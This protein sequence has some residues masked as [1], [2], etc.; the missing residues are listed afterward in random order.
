MSSTGRDRRVVE[1]AWRAFVDGRI[2]NEV[3]PEVV[4]SWR[5]SST[6]PLGID[7]AP[8]ADDAPSRWLASPV[9]R[10]FQSIESELTGVALEGDFVAAVTDADGTIVWT[11]AGRAMRRRAERVHFAPGGRW[12][13]EAV[14]TNALGL[15]LRSDEACTVWSAEHY[16]PIVHDWVCYSAPIHDPVTRRTCGVIDLS[17]TWHQAHPLAL[18]TVKSLARLLDHALTGMGSNGAEHSSAPIDLRTLGRSELLLD[19]RVRSLPPR[20]MELLTVLS[21]HPEGL[22][23]EQLHDRLHGDRRVRPSTTKAEISHLRQVLGDR[24]AS[25]PYRLAGAVTA[26]HHR[27]LDALARH[28]LPAAVAAYAGPLLPTSESP[29]IEEHRHLIDATLRRS[30]LASNDVGLVARLAGA[31]P[32]D[33]ELHE[34][35]VHRLPAS[36]PR[37][38]LASS[39]LDALRRGV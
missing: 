25:R 7:H 20:Q 14:G 28:D 38:A 2:P 36:D 32:F 16:A 10:A 22:T 4:G 1:R 6:I 26:D 30:V 37:H 12:G 33:G 13:E 27:V 17:T 9:S 31:M 3:R 5:R 24:V 23:L 29:S 15:A 11:T 35:I 21:L 19:G 39:R 18:T 8:E 34:F